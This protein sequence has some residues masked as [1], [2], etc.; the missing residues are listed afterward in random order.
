MLKHSLQFKLSQKLSPQQIQLMKLIQLPTQAFEQ[1]LQEELV[2]NPALEESSKDDNYDLDDYEVNSNDDYDDYDNEHID[3]QDINIDEY[4]SNDETPDYKYQTNNY[5]DD[6]EDKSS[7]FAAPVSFH[8]DL[9]N[10]LNTFILTDDERDIAEFL[11]GSIDDMG[12]I[13]RTTQDIVDDMAFTQGIYT[14]ETTVERILHLVQELEPVGVG[15]RDLQECLLLQLKHKTPSD[16]ITLAIHVIEQ[17]FDAFSKKHYDKLLQKFDVSQQQLRKAIDEI[18]KLN[19]K[20]GGSFDGNQKMVEHIVPDFTIRIVDGELELL[21]NG[22]NAPELHVSKDYQEMLQSYKD[23]S[24]KSSAQKDAVQFIKQKLDSA[25]WFIDAIKQ[26]QETL[27][28]TMNAI[29]FYQQE[30]FLDGEETKLRPM[31]LKDIADMVGL[32]ISTV[33]RVANSKYVDTPYGTKLIKEFFSES[34]TNDQGEEVST[35]EIKNILQQVISEEDKRKPLPD[36]QLAEILK[37]RGYPIARRTIAK[38]REQLD[39]PVAR[40]RKK[41]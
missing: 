30:Y 6:D 21:L 37:E 28:V 10:Q 41:I 31:I 38:Y 8:Q 9:I 40:L 20:P 14:D 23:T 19:P 2:E 17:Q 39:I 1:R 16:S 3:A 24:D 12:Y 13:R 22:R 35:I 11:V 32:D 4:L 25:K 29:M 15:A 27:Y 26:R 34:M 5:S 7:P 36:D 33:S 18:E